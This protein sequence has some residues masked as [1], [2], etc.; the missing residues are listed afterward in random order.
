MVWT[1]RL[2]KGRILT[3]AWPSQAH[4]AHGCFSAGLLLLL[5]FVPKDLV[6][7]SPQ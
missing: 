2:R 4:S 6:V 1:S 3:G 5:Q 7:L